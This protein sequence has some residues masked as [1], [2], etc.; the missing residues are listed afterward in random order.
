MAAPGHAQVAERAGWPIAGEYVDHGISSAKGRDQRPEFDRLLKDAT[1]RQF[2][3]VMAWS[4]DRLGRAL[5]DL[6]AV[7][8]DLRA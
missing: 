4:V 3:V 8:G 1:R 2:D 6:V 5:Q 7:F